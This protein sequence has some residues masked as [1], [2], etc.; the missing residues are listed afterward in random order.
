MLEHGRD[1][2]EFLFY[3]LENRK[4]CGKCIGCILF[5]FSPCFCSKHFFCINKCVTNYVRDTCRKACRS[6]SYK[7]S[8]I[9]QTLLMVTD[10]GKTLQYQVSQ[11][12][13]SGC[14]TASCVQTDRWSDFNR[15]PT[16]LRTLKKNS[17]PIS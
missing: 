8:S 14:R 2:Y 6:P 10:F 12:S 1:A 3:Y 15:R 13:F 9:Y 11:N 7:V 4:T 16:G 17:I 5:S